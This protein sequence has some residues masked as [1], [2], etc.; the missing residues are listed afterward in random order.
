MPRRARKEG[1]NWQGRVRETLDDVLRTGIGVF[2]DTVRQAAPRCAYCGTTTP[3]F[4]SAC[5]T[6]VCHGH[7]HINSIRLSALCNGCL[8]KHFPF[9]QVEMRSPD[10]ADVWP[11]AQQPW[12]ILHIAWDATEEEINTAFKRQARS[13]HPDIGGSEEEMRK[14]GAAREYMLRMR[15]GGR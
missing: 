6:P 7:A 2:A 11:H 1:S 12:D 8:S 14:L 4:C 10:E 3:F 15:R 9:V 5:G 13:A